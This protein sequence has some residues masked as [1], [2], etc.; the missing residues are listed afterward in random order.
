M[1]VNGMQACSLA[2][3]TEIEVRKSPHFL[4]YT[5]NSSDNGYILP[6]DSLAFL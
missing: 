5:Q 3:V 6:I 4:S 1:F 2:D